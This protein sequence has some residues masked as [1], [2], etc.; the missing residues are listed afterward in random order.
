MLFHESFTNVAQYAKRHSTYQWQI[1]QDT[2]FLITFFPK[3]VHV[4]SYGTINT[5]NATVSRAISLA[6]L[7]HG[8]MNIYLKSF[9][10]GKEKRLNKWYWTLWLVPCLLVAQCH[11]QLQICST[12]CRIQTDP[13]LEGLR[14]CPI[15]LIKM[16]AKTGNKEGGMTL[17]FYKDINKEAAP[18]S[19]LNSAAIKITK[20][21]TW[22]FS[23]T[24]LYFSP[25]SIF[26]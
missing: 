2:G 16:S 21:S 6:T 23:G 1:L 24:I 20:Q 15:R 26:E 11:Q 25:F 7:N 9:R 13:S 14:N 10:T 22:A 4:F 19:T 12:R 18:A 3:V 8:H 5:R 17:G